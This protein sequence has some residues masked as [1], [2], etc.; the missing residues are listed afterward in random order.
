MSTATATEPE[1]RFHDEPFEVRANPKN[2][3]ELILQGYP[4][5]WDAPS[6]P[7]PYTE[8]VKRGATKGLEGSRIALLYNH[9]HTK[10]PL[11]STWDRSLTW[12]EDDKGVKMR[13]VLNRNRHDCNDLAEAVRTGMLNKMSF[14]FRPGQEQWSNGG[15]VR[16]HFKFASLSDFSVVDDPAYTQTA[17]KIAKRARVD[18]FTAANPVEVRHVLWCAAET[19]K[20]KTISGAN[21][22]KLGTALG[23]LQQAGV[24]IQDLLATNGE[25]PNSFVNLTGVPDAAVGGNLT[26]DQSWNA[27]TDGTGSR[28]LTQQQRDVL[29]LYAE[30]F[31]D[32]RREHE[33]QC[34]MVQEVLD[35]LAQESKD[36]LFKREKR[37]R[38]STAVE[39]DAD[40]LKKMADN[41]RKRVTQ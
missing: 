25:D 40:R 9:D 37:E 18:L 32:E 24:Q 15:Q 23:H 8:Y 5:V 19:R 27:S 29:A 33:A 6:E 31:E 13:A 10:L 38:V 41:L 16:T 12:K 26:G 36:R 28:H 22:A 14:A 2:A 20:G 21:K 3:D 30:M 35:E 11:A 7:I 39:T 34:R 4:I 1:I 17:V